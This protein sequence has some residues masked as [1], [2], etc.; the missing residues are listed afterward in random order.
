MKTRF[1]LV[2]AAVAMV[3]TA[4]TKDNEMPDNTIVYDGVTYQ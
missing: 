4:C 2:L 1:L 3:F